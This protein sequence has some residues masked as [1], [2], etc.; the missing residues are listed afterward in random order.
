[1]QAV[2]KIDAVFTQKKNYEAGGIKRFLYQY[3]LANFLLSLYKTL[4]K[5]RRQ[6]CT[7]NVNFARTTTTFTTSTLSQQRQLCQKVMYDPMKCPERLTPVCM[8]PWNLL[9]YVQLLLQLLHVLQELQ[10]ATTHTTATTATAR[11]TATTAATSPAD[12]TAPTAT[13]ATTLTTTH[14][15]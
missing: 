6:L 11:T 5:E 10:T 15:C 2:K 14:R 13:T 8:A 7:K 4:C 12:S 1:M 3:E 9:R